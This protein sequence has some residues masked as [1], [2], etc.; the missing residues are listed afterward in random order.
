MKKRILPFI[1]MLLSVNSEAIGLLVTWPPIDEAA[2]YN[3]YRST[4][5]WDSPAIKLNPEG[6]LIIGTEWSDETVFGWTRY[7]YTAEAI[8]SNGEVI[9][10]STPQC[11]VHY[12]HG[13][14]NLSNSI[15]IS[16]ATLIA[17]YLV[18]LEDL[19]DAA[20]ESADANLD[21]N[22]SIS[23]VTRIYIHLV[24]LEPIPHCQ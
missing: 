23:D 3:L 10:T 12:C 15:S 8:D 1:F 7:Y 17:R 20:L 5:N 24:G 14:A 6:E 2:G 11:I 21:G 18:G 4:P 19:V 9:A 13:D 16:D 22:V